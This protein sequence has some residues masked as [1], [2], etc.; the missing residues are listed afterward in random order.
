MRFKRFE[1]RTLVLVFLGI[2][3]LGITSTVTSGAPQQPASAS[4]AAPTFSGEVAPIMYAKCVACHRPGEVAPMSLITYKDVRPWASSIREKVTSRVMPPWH[5][6]RQYGTFR[7]EQSLTQSEIDTIVKWVNAGA[8]EGNPSRMP[9]LPK[10]PEGWQIGTPDVVLEMP[11]AYSI[12]AKGEIAYQY[13]EVP[14]NFTEDRWMQAGEVRAGDRAHVHHII[15]YVQEPNPTARPS[16]MTNRPILSAASASPSGAASGTAPAAAPAPSPRP[17]VTQQA[18]RA[19]APRSPVARTGDQML[20]NWAVGEDAP[21][22]LPGMAKR[23]PKGSVL[24]FQVHYTTNG[25]PGTDKSRIGL[26]FAKVSGFHRAAVDRR[27]GNDLFRERSLVERI[28][29]AGGDL[30]VR[31]GEITILKYVAG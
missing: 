13:F 14:T 21:M 17:A 20:V 28:A 18:P 22:F 16:V 30:P 26:I 31:P 15:V 9:A 5:A 2:V 19:A 6:D 7:N 3:W 8:P 25:T 27:R 23:I 1:T 11:A 24:V 12:P 4:A 29:S 10:F